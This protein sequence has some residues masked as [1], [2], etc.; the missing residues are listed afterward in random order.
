MTYK[1]M[2]QNPNLF[3]IAPTDILDTALPIEIF[4][5]VD[6]DGILI[7]N[8]YHTIR[9]AIELG[10]HTVSRINNDKSKF[11]KGFC[12]TM[13]TIDDLRSMMPD[14]RLEYGVDIKLLNTFQVVEE[15][16]EDEWVSTAE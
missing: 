10:G 12:F 2:M 6:E 7:P 15:L 8:E 9:E 11:F 5:K 3:I 14:F 16:A 1:Q 4:N 13:D